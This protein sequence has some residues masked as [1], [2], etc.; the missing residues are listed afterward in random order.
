MPALLLAVSVGTTEAHAGLF[1]RAGKPLGSAS[2]EFE[3]LRPAPDQAVYRMD[4][5]WDAAATAIRACLRLVPGAAGRVAGL[6]FSAAAALVLEHDGPPLLAGDADVFAVTDRRA[7][8]EAAE[9]TATRDPFLSFTGG[10]VSAAMHLPRLL[11]LRRHG[12]M[13]WMRVTAAR[14]L[15][16]ELTRRATGI[17]AASLG[18][19]VTQWP[20]LPEGGWRQ[21][22]LDRIG[23]DDLPMLGALSSPPHAVGQ[24][25]GPLAREVAASL[26]LPAGIPVAAGLIDTQAATLGVLGRGIR[27]RMNE[28]LALIVSDSATCLAFA[29]D[30]RMIPRVRG[31]FRDAVFPGYWLHV[32]EQPGPGNAAPQADAAAA[33]EV[34]A[35][36]DREATEFAARLPVLPE[37]P[38]DHPPAREAVGRRAFLEAYYVAVRAAV[39]RVRRM[40]AELNANGYAIGRV[41]LTG[42]AGGNR[43]LVR[44]C[45]DALGADLV[46]TQTAHPALL[47]TAMVAAV[48]ARVYPDLFIAL[49]LMSSP[50]HRFAADSVWRRAH[51]AAYRRFLDHAE[52]GADAKRRAPP[53]SAR[54]RR[55]R[56]PA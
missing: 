3:L 18:C 33:A 37:G 13:T 22:L 52:Q 25:H 1:D 39:L 30:E 54:Q 19:L 11:W 47:G 40:I 14:D 17:A 35:L 9:I 38:A 26:G 32:A 34:V 44:L 31:P 49:D 28:T 43:L 48:A 12:P 46:L 24:R 15:C 8:A 27:A 20:Y 6:G 41:A 53:R 2:Q 45:R 4:A 16:D 51:E 29:P 50:Q 36:L 5:I 21:A 10:A 42:T 56:S 7:E 55:S 23:L